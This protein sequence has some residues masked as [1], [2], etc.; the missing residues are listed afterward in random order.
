MTVTVIMSVI[1]LAMIVPSI[2]TVR[3][4]GSGMIITVAVMIVT[5][6]IVSDL[7][8]AVAIMIVVVMVVVV[9]RTSVTVI[10]SVMALAVI[11]P[12]V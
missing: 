9:I 6:V 3:V 12:S 1:A 10:V 7:T 2:G 5:E 4:G 8:S 11:V